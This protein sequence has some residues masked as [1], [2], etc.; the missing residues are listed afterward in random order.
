MKA[1]FNFCLE[2]RRFVSGLWLILFLILSACS[3]E[4]NTITGNI[5]HNLTAHFNG[6]YYAREKARDVQGLILANHED[7][8]SQIL[9]LFP[10][11]DTTFAKTYSSDTEEIVKMA[12]ISIQRHPNSKWAD[13]NY[14]LAGRARYYD[15]DFQNA[16]I[17]FKYVNTN[18]HETDTRH[19]A[20]IY[21]LRTFTETLA[22]NTSPITRLFLM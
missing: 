13:D 5:Y 21:L 15:G 18:S 20:L 11:L 8:P 3:S 1:S 19:E 22:F 16:I 4:Q 12:S 17:T 10:E 6:Y 7:D 2:K 14:I 9:R